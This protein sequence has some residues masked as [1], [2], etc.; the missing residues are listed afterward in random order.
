MCKRKNSLDKIKNLQRSLNFRL[1]F[2]AV[3]KSLR[4][5]V[6]EL[7]KGGIYEERK[8]TEDEMQRVDFDNVAS[9]MNTS[10][11]ELL[12]NNCHIIGGLSNMPS[13]YPMFVN[14]VCIPFVEALYQASKFPLHPQVQRKIVGESNAMR[15]KVVSRKYQNIVRADW[16]DIRFEV[17]E[18]CLKVKLLQNWESF[19]GVLRSTAGLPIVE[20][21]TKDNIWGQCLTALVI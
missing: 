18:W 15:A 14:E 5:L 20:Y 7:Y 2:Y 6:D 10:I 16:N 21:S 11:T 3:P 9:C 19:G 1:D 17:M 13:K 8:P 12:Y 4:Q